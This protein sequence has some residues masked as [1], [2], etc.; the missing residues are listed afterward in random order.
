M[1]RKTEANVRFIGAYRVISGKTQLTIE[2]NE[3]IS[4]KKAVQKIAEGLPRLKR[5]L[6][7]PKLEDP[8]PNAL[9]L[10][11]GRE[12]SVLNGL[13]TML[14]SGDEMIFIPVSHGG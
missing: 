5:V 2:H 9:I 6:I 11:N 3:T 14:T 10:L 1:V 12:I 13:E 8:T 7:D 4:V